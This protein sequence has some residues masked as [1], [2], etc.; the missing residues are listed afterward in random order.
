[1]RFARSPFWAIPLLLFVA[2]CAYRELSPPNAPARTFPDVVVP[3]EP[4]E[5]GTTRVVLDANGERAIVTEV[6]SWT[7]SRGWVEGAATTLSTVTEEER[8]V[9]IAPCT[10]ALPRGMH[11]LRFKAPSGARASEVALQVDERSKV[12]RHAM[13]GVEEGSGAATFSA[14]MLAILGGTAVMVGG[15]LFVPSDAEPSSTTETRHQTGAALMIGGGAAVA[16]SVPLFLLARGTRQPGA[17]TE[18]N[19]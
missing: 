1:M 16:L 10:V 18:F 13:G 17:T 7:S 3:D 6:K 15:L 4:P 2:G 11:V 8:P 14:I 9:C 5:K 19:F 12:V